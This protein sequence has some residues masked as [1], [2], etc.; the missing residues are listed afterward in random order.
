MY[1]GKTIVFVMHW[2]CTENEPCHVI[3]VLFVLR[4]SILQT[5]VRNHPMGLYVMSSG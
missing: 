3:M 2:H 5:R 4:K 1:L